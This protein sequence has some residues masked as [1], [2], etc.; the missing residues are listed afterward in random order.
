MKPSCARGTLIKG[1]NSERCSPPRY[2]W[3]GRSHCEGCVT[4]LPAIPTHRQTNII[5]ATREVQK[6]KRSQ[7]SK[8]NGNVQLIWSSIGGRH[9]HNTA[10]KQHSEESSQ[11]HG[12]GHIRDLQ[13]PG[14]QS[15]HYDYFTGKGGRLYLKLVKADQTRV[16][17]NDMCH[18]NNRVS[19]VARLMLPRMDTI[20]DLEHKLIEMNAPF[21]LDLEAVC[22]RFYSDHNTRRTPLIPAGGTPRPE[23]YLYIEEKRIHKHRL[24]CANIS[25]QVQPMGRWFLFLIISAK[26]PRKQPTFPGQSRFARPGSIPRRE[27]PGI[28]A[29]ERDSV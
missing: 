27:S 13:L 1:T 9:H 24:P 7:K 11:N 8:E 12:I 3:T 10:L 4:S 28:R 6:L 29:G 2:L 14:Q 5:R 26:K 23:P 16:V 15:Q 22:I 21:F 20:V 18:G 17:R 25:I 19:S